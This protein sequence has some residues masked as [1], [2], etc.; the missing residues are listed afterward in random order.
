MTPLE[1][2][3][4]DVS[5]YMDDIKRLFKPGVKIAVLV[6]TPGYPERDFM[7]TDDKIEELAAMIERRSQA[8]RG[9]HQTSGPGT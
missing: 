4:H 7:M 2:V 8:E 3:Q 1:M 6:R 5:E 9:L